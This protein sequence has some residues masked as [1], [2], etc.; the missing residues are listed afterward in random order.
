MLFLCVWRR[1]R[2]YMENTPS[3]MVIKL[4]VTQT[5][6]LKYNLDH[7]IKFLN[8]LT[9]YF[10]HRV[11]GIRILYRKLTTEGLATLDVRLVLCSHC[12]GRCE[13]VQDPSKWLGHG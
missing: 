8:I 4:L 7:P 9:R 6:P 3:H 13:L 10:W 2:L 5:F 11:A 1:P 12:N